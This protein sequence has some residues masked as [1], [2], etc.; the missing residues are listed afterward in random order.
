MA[1][2]TSNCAA[3]WPMTRSTPE[4]LLSVVSIAHHQRVSRGPGPPAIVEE[5]FGDLRGIKGRRQSTVRG[6]SERL[7]VVSAPILPI[8]TTVGIRVCE[9]RFGTHPAQVFFTWNTATHVTS[10]DREFGQQRQGVLR[11][12]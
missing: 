10:V 1:G 12:C 9:Q 3:I 11:H 2:V 6:L 8:P 5:F 7:A 4:S